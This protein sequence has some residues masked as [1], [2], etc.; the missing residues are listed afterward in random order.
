MCGLTKVIIAGSVGIGQSVKD[1]E[2]KIYQN[3]TAFLRDTLANDLEEFIDKDD[4]KFLKNESY[5]WFSLDDE[6][7]EA[8]IEARNRIEESSG[9]K[10]REIVFY[11]IITQAQWIGVKTE[12]VMPNPDNRMDDLRFFLAYL[13]RGI[14]LGRD[15]VRTKY[16]A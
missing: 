8:L 7:F 12:V 13:L 1:L 14:V 4:E 10:V 11:D 9:E 15:V 6:L 16:A 5:E 3:Q 2:D